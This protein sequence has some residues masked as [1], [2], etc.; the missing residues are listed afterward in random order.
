MTYDETPV[1]GGSTEGLPS[2]VPLFPIRETRKLRVPP[3]PLPDGTRGLDPLLRV[4]RWYPPL[5]SLLPVTFGPRVRP[6]DRQSS[7][8]PHSHP[9]RGG[10]SFV[11]RSSPT[12]RG[13]PGT[14]SF[15][16]IPLFLSLKTLHRRTCLQQVSGVSTPR[17]LR[18]SRSLGEFMWG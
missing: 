4:G 13:F 1:G 11:F 6:V 8:P 15:H 7:P 14:Y 5:D 9:H 3:F 18:G 10:V 12:Q 2:G 16:R 17:L